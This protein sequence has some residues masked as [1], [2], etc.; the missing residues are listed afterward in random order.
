MH[1]TAAALLGLICLLLGCVP[2]QTPAERAD[3]VIALLASRQFQSFASYV[4]P[5]AGVRFSPAA[6]IDL[7]RDR[8]LSAGQLA[9]APNDQQTYLWGFA[10]GSGE[11]IELTFGDYVDR[12]LYDADFAQAETVAVDQ[13]VGRGS[14]VNNLAKVY[15]NGRFVEYHFS[16]FDPQF[17]GMDWKSLR[18]VFEQQAG[19]W[20]LVGIIHDQWSP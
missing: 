8:V 7:E 11:P 20:Y 13:V 12:Y 1:K 14:T 17:E 15:P 6:Y 3:E 2:Q 10:A 16:G 5:D 4:H 19:I 18:L 9:V